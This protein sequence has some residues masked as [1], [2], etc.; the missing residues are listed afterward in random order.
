[1]RKFAD[2][3][4]SLTIMIY[5][6]FVF[7]WFRLVTYLLEENF[8]DSDLA[9]ARSL[10]FS[11]D[12]ICTIFIY[13][14]PKFLT[15]DEEEEKG[16]NVGQQSETP[17]EKQF[18]ELQ[19]MHREDEEDDDDDEF[20][21]YGEVQPETSTTRSPPVVVNIG[22]DGHP[23]YDDKPSYHRQ[24]S[25]GDMRPSHQARSPEPAMMPPAN[26]AQAGLSDD[27]EDDDEF[28]GYGDD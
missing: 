26:L 4:Q 14:V 28:P 11:A 18:K 8:N 21:G 16:L 15:S 19:E 20:P 5:S 24:A 27:D 25:D 1:M 9:L 13:F 22:N 2:E 12:T 7:V 6:H 10:V 23:G 3:S 17:S